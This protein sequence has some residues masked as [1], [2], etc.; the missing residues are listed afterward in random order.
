MGGIVSTQWLADHLDEL[1]LRIIDARGSFATYEEAHIPGAQM[2]HIE[3][4]RMS[5]NGM[6]C[7]MFTPEVLGIIFGRLGITTTTPV[8]IYATNPKD[9]ISA[10][11][12]AWS[13]AVTGNRAVHVLDGGLDKWTDEDRVETQQFPYIESAEYR[14]AFD[15]TIFADWQYVINHLDDSRVALVDTRTQQMYT[16]ASGPTQRRGHI[17]GAVLHNYLWDFRSDGSYL[18]LDKLRKR[19]EDDGITP[20]KEIITYC[21]TGREGS[22]A[23]YI[24]KEILGYPH[25]R[26]YQ[27]SMTEWTAHPELPLVAGNKP[28]ST[29]KAA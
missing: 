26:L 8:V 14:A 23:W 25:V 19:Y 1:G 2:L 13:L 20:D 6:P 7:K 4:L 18:P 12:T 9:H 28:W 3:T 22:A 29:R 15:P 11:Y 24:L 21:V 5:E 16:G 17:P 10:T 27:A